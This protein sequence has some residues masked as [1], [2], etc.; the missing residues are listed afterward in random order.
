[1]SAKRSGQ[2][3]AHLRDRLFAGMINRQV[4]TDV[5]EQVYEALAAFAGFGLAESHWVAFAHLMYS[6]AWSKV[7][8][9]AA[10]A[11]GLL[12][13]QP[14]GSGPPGASWPTPSARG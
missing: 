5:A 7:H 6:T 3:M 4:S 1:M 13:A 8:Y 2:R 11:A 12:N 10:F 14:M 9:P